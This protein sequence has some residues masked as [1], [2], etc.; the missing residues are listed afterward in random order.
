MIVKYAQWTFQECNIESW[1][2]GQGGWVSVDLETDQEISNRV[3]LVKLVILEVLVLLVILVLLVLLVPL[4]LL[5][6][7]VLLVSHTFL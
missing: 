3:I 6:L 5:V 1:V 7:N 2:K 4:I